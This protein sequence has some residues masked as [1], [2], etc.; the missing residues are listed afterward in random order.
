M[1]QI[2]PKDPEKYKDAEAALGGA[3][4]VEKT[5]YVGDARGAE[6]TDPRDG[7]G[8]YSATVRPGGGPGLIVWAAAIL[9]IAALVAYLAGAF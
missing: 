4:N 6:P 5:T 1:A 9:A 8:S 7:H 2:N 3:D